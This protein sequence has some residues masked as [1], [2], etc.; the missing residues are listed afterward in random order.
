[1]E[2]NSTGFFWPYCAKFSHNI[3]HN[4]FSPIFIMKNAKQYK[5]ER[6]I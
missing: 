6:V 5:V 4:D 2:L 1:M 3:T